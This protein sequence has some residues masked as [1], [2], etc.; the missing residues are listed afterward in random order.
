MAKSLKSI[1]SHVKAIL[2]RGGSSAD[3]ADDLL[4]DAFVKLARYSQS[5]E[6]LEP[7]AWLVRVARRLFLDARRARRRRG[8]HVLLDER[9]DLID[10]GP[11]LEE[12][13]MS[14]EQLELV[15]ETFR[16]MDAKTSRIILAHRIEGTSYAD[17]AREHGITVSAVEKQ[18]ANAMTLLQEAAERGWP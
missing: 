11:G 10:P 3:E 12:V 14:R 18:I 6:V 9:L 5:H 4:Q 15:S 8:E 13:L 16:S 1:M 2:M 7:E 17:I